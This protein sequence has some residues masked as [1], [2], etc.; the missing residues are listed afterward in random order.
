MR[1]NWL[2]FATELSGGTSSAFAYTALP[3]LGIDEVTISAI[4]MLV[5]SAEIIAVC[6]SISKR[7]DISTTAVCKNNLSV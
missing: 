3:A 5:Y 4:I 1:L 2:S 7:F 6:V